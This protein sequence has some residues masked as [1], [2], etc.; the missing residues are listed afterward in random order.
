V[1]SPPHVTSAIAALQ[2]HTT[3]GANQPAQ[4]AAVTAYSDPRVDEDVQ[5]MVVAFRRRRDLLA[6]RIREE[7]PGVQFVEPH[8]AFYLF[9]RVDGIAPGLGGAGFC[10]QLMQDTGVALVPGAAFGDDRWVRL[11]YSVS[12]RELE[13]ALDR[14]V[15]FIRRLGGH[16]G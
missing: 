11:S 12:D 5:K 3:T 7:A 16:G 2:S 15:P 9:F 8:G 4:W 6:R 1:L 10:T 14:I 13:R